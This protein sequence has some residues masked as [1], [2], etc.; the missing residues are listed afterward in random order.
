M[1]LTQQW[2][3]PG[4]PSIGID[5]S[6][7]CLFSGVLC[8]PHIGFALAREN[9]VVRAHRNGSSSCPS[10]PMKPPARGKENARAWGGSASCLSRDQHDPN[11]SESKIGLQIGTLVN[12]NIKPADFWW[13]NY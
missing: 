8:F 4:L 12:G 1:L 6:R 3:V 9:F 2:Q 7:L 11:G 10:C 13:F 5:K